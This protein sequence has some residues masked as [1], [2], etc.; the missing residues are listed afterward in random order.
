MTNSSNPDRGTVFD[1]PFQTARDRI[2]SPRASAS[3]VTASR[4]AAA[5]S[6]LPPRR[7]WR[8]ALESRIIEVASALMAD[9]PARRSVTRS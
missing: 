5:A 8:S 9:E 7:R 3:P 4:P 6:A 1:L 2:T